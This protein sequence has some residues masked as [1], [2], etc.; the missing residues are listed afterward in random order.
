MATRAAGLLLHPTSLPDGPGALAARAGELLAWMGDAGLSVWQVLPL[1]PAGPG[2]SPYSATSLFAIAP[3]WFPEEGAGDPH[4]RERF[5]DE[6]R[7]WLDD[8]CVFAALSEALRIPWTSWDLPL[9]TREA[10]ALRSASH[11]LTDA[12]ARHRE[13]QVRAHLGWRSVRAEAGRRGIR[14]LG[15]VPIYPALESVDV[16]ARQD[17][18][19][20]DA[21][22]KPSKVAGVPPDYFSSTGQLWGN[23]VYRWNRAAEEGFAWWIRRLRR[24]LDL[25]DA[26]R[27]DHFRGFAGYWAVEAGAPTA[28]SGAWE[29]GP[30]RALFEAARA[31]LGGL[32]FVAEDLGVITEDVVEL[33]HGLGLPG[34]RVLQFG[35]LDPG[36]D[37]APHR[38]SRD[39]VV[40]TGT[41]DNDTTRGWFE[42]LDERGKRRVLAIAGGT[43]DD[44]ARGV[45]RVAMGSVADLA[46]VPMQDVL[47]KD[48][49]ARMNVPGRAAGNWGWAMAPGE[50]SPEVARSLREIVEATGRAR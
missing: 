49:R 47:G 17:L 26:L 4:E 43:P 46:I 36:S 27:L 44:V 28:E 5:L 8:W 39:V 29:P 40:Y 7:D 35:L 21:E 50:M 22:G 14:I 41:H 48:G 32:P 1:S 30:G 25:H 13:A 19:D 3:A 12:T 24:Q 31:A 42:T 33:R 34:M 18:F 38:L 2:G 9:R 23:P 45:L 10:G 6:N 37:H 15:D 11:E 16:W 20:L